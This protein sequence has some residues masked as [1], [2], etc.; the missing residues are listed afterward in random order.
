MRNAS[1][2]AAERAIES[3]HVYRCQPLRAKAGQNALL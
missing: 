1:R 3:G 2:D